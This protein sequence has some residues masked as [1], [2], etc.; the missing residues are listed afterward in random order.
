MC[1]MEI[2]KWHP[3]EVVRKSDGNTVYESASQ[4]VKVSTDVNYL[5]WVSLALPFVITVIPLYGLPN[6][7][8]CINLVKQM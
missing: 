3:R 2:T 8:M 6:L 4:L 5:S 7:P 1:K